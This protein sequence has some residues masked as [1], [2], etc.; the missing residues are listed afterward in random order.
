MSERFATKFSG[1]GSGGD[2]R[3]G[4]PIP[5][6]AD[7]VVLGAGI[8]GL[9]VAYE[10]SRLRPDWTVTVLEKDEVP[11]GTMRS[12]RI[13]GCLCEWGPNGFLTNVPHTWDFAHE[14]GL[15]D[16]LAVA[17]HRAERRFL[18]VGGRLQEVHPHPVKFLRS[19]LLSARGKA[20][21]LLEPFVP[22]KRDGADESVFSFAARRIGSE[23]A[24][25]LVD[26]MVTGIHAGDSRELSLRATFPKMVGMEETYGGLVKAMIALKRA[27]RK[28][29]AASG[30]GPA[31]PGGRL[32]SFDEGMQV[33]VDR[34]ALGVPGLRVSAPVSAVRREHGGYRV[35]LAGGNAV[36]APRVVVAA[37]APAAA[38][39]LGDDFPAAA[40]PIASIDYAGIAVVCLVYRREQVAH[41][42]DGF[43]FLVP[44]GESPRLLG[45]I[46]V[47]SIFPGHAASGRVVLRAMVGGAR[48]PEGAALPE[49]RLVDGVRKDLSAILGGLDGPPEEA[50]VYRHAKG[51]PQYR[52]GH[53]DRVA[54]I[55][56]ALGGE[57]GLHV[58]GNAYR[59]IG[60][61][62]C[63]REARALAERLVRAGERA[64]AGQRA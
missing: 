31:G 46:W 36:R 5:E 35:E 17:D 10:V 47:G 54:A 42:L 48:D 12:D 62:D 29:G 40:G 61:N 33:L 27:R 26:A 21:L 64:P 2:A 14:L 4:Q 3:S 63:V 25:R 11:G 56:S 50:V 60:V 53:L 8:S 44:R 15:A 41:T 28:A 1:N 7:L 38:A 19:G 24:A 51:I 32:V 18:F 20:R 57:P 45:C 30:G 59:G 22:A 52:L 34:L 9:A 23:A 39:L 13:A 49:G 37:P 58:A 55:E 6:R 43:G 16:R